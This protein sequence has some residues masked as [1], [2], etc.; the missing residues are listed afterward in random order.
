MKADEIRAITARVKELRQELE[1]VEARL[2]E[3]SGDGAPLAPIESIDSPTVLT[4]NHAQRRA[5]ADRMIPFFAALGAVIVLAGGIAIGYALRPAPAPLPPPAAQAVAVPAPT[6]SAVPAS[7]PAPPA[8][9][10][11]PAES[12]ATSAI[13]APPVATLAIPSA[14]VPPAPTVSAAPVRAA[15]APLRKVDH[16]F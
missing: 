3:V 5:Q 7:A 6:P 10:P 14:T 15:T 12:A 11:S 2:R 16:G 8:P 1:S 13:V 9:A 4:T